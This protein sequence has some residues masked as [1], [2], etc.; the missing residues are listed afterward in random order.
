MM[1]EMKKTV[2][3]QEGNIMQDTYIKEK[4]NDFSRTLDQGE[5]KL[6]SAA[7]DAQKKLQQGQE[8]VQRLI[9]QADKQ[10]H[11]NPWPIVAGVAVGCL[12]LGFFAGNVRS[13]S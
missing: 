5:Q 13:R 6:K 2:V 1:K 7:C 11:E 3:N 8:Q 10:L 4:E 12:F 9:S